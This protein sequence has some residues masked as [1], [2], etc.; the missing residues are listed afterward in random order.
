MSTR[1]ARPILVLGL[2]LLTDPLDFYLALGC[3]RNQRSKIA[4]LE[5][6]RAVFG[7]SSWRK[8]NFRVPEYHF[9][10]S[11]HWAVHQ[12]TCFWTGPELMWPYVRWT[13]LLSDCRDFPSQSPL[14]EGNI[15][16]TY[17]FPYWDLWSK[18]YGVIF[19][20]GSC[21]YGGKW[22]LCGP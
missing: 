6:F 19:S 10:S 13:N 22:G 16:G 11:V 7:F 1:F 12:P 18:R 8:N 2:K 4:L 21:F 3:D 20:E 17:T 9:G 5:S 15:V 14:L